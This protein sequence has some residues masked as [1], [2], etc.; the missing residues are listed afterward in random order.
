MGK[1]EKVAVICLENVKY[2]VLYDADY[3]ITDKQSVGT[4]NKVL[5]E[6]E[7]SGFILKYNGYG[8]K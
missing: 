4:L 2:R 1:C 6:L 8:K 5:D 7:Y 3:V